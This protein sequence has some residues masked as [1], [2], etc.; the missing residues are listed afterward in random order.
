MFR[1]P[2][3]ARR[4]LAQF[5]RSHRSFRGRDRLLRVAD[6]L[7]RKFDADPVEEAIAGVRFH[8]DTEDLI[9][10]R[11]LY[12]GIH[13]SDLVNYVSARLGQSCAVFWDVGANIGFV[14]LCIA[15]RNMGV[16]VHAFEPSPSVHSR[17]AQ[18][19][20]RNPRLSPRIH[21]HRVALSNTRGPVQFFVSNEP[22]NS[23]VGGLGPSHNRDNVPVEVFAQQGDDLIAR[24]RMSPPDLIKIDVEGFEMEVLRGLEHFLRTNSNVE[25]VFEHEPYRLS[26]RSMNKRAVIEYLR[27]LGFEIRQFADPKQ[28]LTAPL[29]ETTLERSCDLVAR[30][31][32]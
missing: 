2:Q 23:G 5:S 10:F 31:A 15:S 3:K 8:L 27:G 14:S 26:E 29:A 9:D 32:S 11:L 13:Q 16:E 4:L 6:R 18:N 30:K 25:L 17:L 24:G 21:I 7:L 19:V 28:G 20:R 1:Y 12:L 22:F